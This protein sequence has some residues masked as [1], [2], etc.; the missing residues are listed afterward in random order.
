MH[1]LLSPKNLI[2]AGLGVAVIGLGTVVTIDHTA[3]AAP[4]PQAASLSS[5]TTASQLGTAAFGAMGQLKGE[6][7]QVFGF[8]TTDTHLTWQQIR[9]DLARGETLDQI[10]GAN[11]TKVEGDAL[12]EVSAGLELGLAKGVISASAEARLVADARDAISV[13]MTAKLSA[14]APSGR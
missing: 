3:A 10:A 13:L 4:A 12:K 14:L 5:A 6:A 8:F 7:S 9:A 11:A 1:P 2:I